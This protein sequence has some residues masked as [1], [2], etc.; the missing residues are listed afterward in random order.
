MSTDSIA[1]RVIEKRI[2]ELKALA[3]SEMVNSIEFSY[4]S[5]MREL[6]RIKKEIQEATNDSDR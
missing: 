2:K 5:K 1:I 4:R 3:E 6:K